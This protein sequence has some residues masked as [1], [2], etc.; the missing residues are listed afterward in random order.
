MLKRPEKYVVFLF[1]CQILRIHKRTFFVYFS[2]LYFLR[3]YLLNSS[4]N[5]ANSL[6]KK[7]FDIKK[8]KR[9]KKTKESLGNATFSLNLKK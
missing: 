4:S 3:H 6:H 2:D 7:S 8:E 9:G 5:E 1:P